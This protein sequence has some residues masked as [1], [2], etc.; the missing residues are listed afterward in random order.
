MILYNSKFILMTSSL[1]TNVV[2]VTGVHCISS[3][4]DTIF[5][6]SLQTNFNYYME[7]YEHTVINV[8]ILRLSKDYLK[9]IYGRRV[10]CQYTGA[11]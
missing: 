1:G 10:C 7:I 9:E 4:R 11:L 2:I 5:F 6:C 8:I 3:F